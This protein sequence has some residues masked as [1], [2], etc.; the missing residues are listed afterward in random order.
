MKSTPPEIDET[1]PT[2][3]SNA[4]QPR[5]Q[6]LLSQG[7]A[8]N[9]RISRQTY[10]LSVEPTRRIRSSGAYSRLAPRAVRTAT[11]AGRLVA[12]KRRTDD[13]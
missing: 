1:L 6:S 3:L 10:R 2:G 9:L 12:I 7:E 11:P 13:A 8:W 5:R 4:P